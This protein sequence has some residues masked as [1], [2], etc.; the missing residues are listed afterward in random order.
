[1]CRCCPSCESSIRVRGVLAGVLHV[2]GVRVLRA[3]D[4][5]RAGGVLHGYVLR[6]GECV[7]LHAG[8]GLLR[9]WKCVRPGGGLLAGGGLL[10][11]A[12][13][14]GVG[15]PSGVR[16][17]VVGLRFRCCRVGGSIHQSVA[18]RP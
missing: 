4:V 8:D 16:L 14:L 9:T 7:V 15:V 5:H 1:M 6:A 3:G 10:R 12:I 18:H 2:G 17:G 13:L 11:T